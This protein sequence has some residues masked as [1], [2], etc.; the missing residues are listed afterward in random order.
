MQQGNARLFMKYERKLRAGQGMDIWQDRAFLL[1]DSGMC[2]VYDLKSRKEEA[3]AFFPLGSY[4]E[5]T[6][7]R[8]YRNHAN[9]CMFGSVIPEG[10]DMPLLYVT[11]GSGVGADA[12]GFYYRCAVEE[13]SRSGESDYQ[14]R[15]LQVIT[16]QPEDM[17][18]LSWEQPSWGCPAFFADEEKKALYI[19]SARYRTKRGCVPEGKKNAYIVTKFDLPDVEKGGM[20]R[21]TP[22]DIRDQ[23]SVESEVLFTQGG[24]LYAGK[25]YYTFGCPS[26]DYPDQVMVFDLEKKRLLAHIGDMDEGFCREEIE[27]CARYGDKFLCNTSTGSIYEVDIR[28]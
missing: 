26:H 21:L 22:R 15:T 11:V 14:A 13:I 20:I 7:S 3:L 19:F 25:I 12:D 5:G 10:K 24:A 6:P 1:F 4:N 18:D 23:F 2:G 16:Y 8:E 17:G 9:S 27:C 28:I